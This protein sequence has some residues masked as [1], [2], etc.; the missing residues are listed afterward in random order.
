MRNLRQRYLL[1]INLNW[2]INFYI[3]YDKEIMILLGMEN[4]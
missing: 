4:H 3:T 2:Q 1:V